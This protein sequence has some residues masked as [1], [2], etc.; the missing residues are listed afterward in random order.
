MYSSNIKLDNN[1]PLPYCCPIYRDEMK[2]VIHFSLTY[3]TCEFCI[4][5]VTI[6]KSMLKF[7]M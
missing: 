5:L 1:F 4:L 7:V 2:I 6:K 3:Y